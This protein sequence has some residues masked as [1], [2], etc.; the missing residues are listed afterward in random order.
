MTN[1]TFVVFKDGKPISNDPKESE[2]LNKRMKV[3]DKVLKEMGYPE[4]AERYSEIMNE[5]GSEDFKKYMEFIERVDKE[6]GKEHV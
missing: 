3:I 1:P 5:L 6:T 4:G 2:R